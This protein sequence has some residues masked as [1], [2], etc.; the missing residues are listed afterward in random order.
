MQIVIKSINIISIKRFY[1]IVHFID[2]KV[3]NNKNCKRKLMLV[4][5]IVQLKS[6]LLCTYFLLLFKD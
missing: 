1:K 3:V 6:K 2:I 4:M 5:I